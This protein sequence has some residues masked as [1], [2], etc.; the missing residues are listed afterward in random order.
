MTINAMS[1]YSS[2]L[3]VILIA[4]NTSIGIMPYFVNVSLE[5][6]SSLSMLCMPFTLSQPHLRDAV[7]CACI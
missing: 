7:H 6:Q 2:Y 3:F 5:D 1:P 4:M